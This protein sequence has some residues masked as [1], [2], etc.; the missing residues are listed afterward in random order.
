MNNLFKSVTTLSLLIFIMLFSSSPVLLGQ[1][2][3]NRQQEQK[4]YKNSIKGMVMPFPFL[5]VLTGGSLSVGYE[6]KIN[7]TLSIDI[8]GSFL[9]TRDE[10]DYTK[11]NLSAMPGL[12]YYFKKKKEKG[13]QFKTEV[14]L[15]YNYQPADTYSDVLHWYGAG[16]LAGMQLNISHNQRWKLDLALGA[17]YN[18]VTSHNLYILDVSHY[19]KLAPRPVIHIVHTF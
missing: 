12:I 18:Y 7:T 5:F 3:A 9:Y 15:H 2:T 17:S 14:Y 16:L 13:P 19:W 8:T 4:E 10:M 6:R 11:M 1:E